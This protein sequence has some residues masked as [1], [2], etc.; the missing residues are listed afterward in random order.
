MSAGTQLFERILTI[1][2]LAT[3]VTECGHGEPVLFIHGS[4]PGLTGMLSFEPILPRMS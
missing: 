2:G 4:G 3:A 1:D